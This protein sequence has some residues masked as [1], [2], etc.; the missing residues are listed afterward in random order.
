[1]KLFAGRTAGEIVTS[2]LLKASSEHGSIIKI[3]MVS[4]LFISQLCMEMLI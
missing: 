3:L 1:M 4:L 2:L